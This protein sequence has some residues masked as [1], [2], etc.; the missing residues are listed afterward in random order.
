MT[1][2]KDIIESADVSVNVKEAAYDMLNFV[3]ELFGDVYVS[4]D[5]EDGSIEFW[6]TDSMDVGMSFSIKDNG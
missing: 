1:C 5:P 4:F 6:E 3:E 2:P